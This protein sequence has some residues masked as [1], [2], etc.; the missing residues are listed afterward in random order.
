MTQEKQTE[1]LTGAVILNQLALFYNEEL[2][3][4]KF[5][6]K[7]LKNTLIKAI[8][9]LMI[10]EKNEFDKVFNADAEYTE[11][12][13]DN[14]TN[15]MLELSKGG[16]ADMVLMGNMMVAYKKDPKAINGIVNKVLSK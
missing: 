11:K 6:K 3:H 1:T 10:A 14:V 5:Y 15:I 4:T 13:S 12:I 9:Q 8:R 16:F 2:K 7:P